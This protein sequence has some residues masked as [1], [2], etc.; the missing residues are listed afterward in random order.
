MNTTTTPAS[1]QP[2]AQAT[3]TAA[4]RWSPAASD[5]PPTA[6]RRRMLRP[7]P[8]DFEIFRQAEI[9]GLSH[10]EIALTSA[11]VTRRRVSQIVARV[12]RWLS[13]HPCDDP[14][15]ASELQ[16]KQL[17][18]HVERLHLEHIVSQAR[19]ELIYGKRELATTREKDD[20]TKTKTIREQPFNVQA[21]KIYLKS[22]QA[23]AKLQQQPDVNLPTPEEC[24]FPWLEGAI[25]EVWDQWMDRVASGRMQPQCIADMVNQMIAA[26]LKAAATQARSAS[27]GA[28]IPL[29]SGEGAERSEAGEGVTADVN[30]NTPSPSTAD[31]RGITSSA[32]PT[33]DLGVGTLASASNASHTSHPEAP[34]S[35]HASPTPA[36]ATA[37]PADTSALPP[38]PEPPPPGPPASPKN[39]KREALPAHL[40]PCPPVPLSLPPSVV[41]IP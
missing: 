24:Q 36:A 26:A 8:R 16:R 20:D 31:G 40:S 39:E 25:N 6:I 22:V 27:A 15:L 37:S 3:G 21:L 11:T 18:R 1:H 23:L 28:E 2:A 14:R 17:A 29:P 33:S 12:R 34:P 30:L 35:P 32:A 9:L 38:P 19:D 7:T 4:K 41:P 13:L 10:A 5:P